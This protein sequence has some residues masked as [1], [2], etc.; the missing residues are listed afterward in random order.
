MLYLGSFVSLLAPNYYLGVV[1]EALSYHANCFMFYTGSPQTLKRLPTS[2][3]KIAEG[4]KLL[5]EKKINENKIVIHAPFVINIANSF[6]R[7]LQLLTI[8]FLRTELKRAQDFNVNFLVLHPGCHVGAGEKIGIKTA[9]ETLNAVL[10][11]DKTNVKIALETMA[12]K[13]SELG[14]NFSQLKK[15]ITGVKHSERLGVCF[16]TCHLHDAGYNVHRIDDLLNEFEQIIGLHKL[17]VIHINDAKFP[18]G[19]HYD[20]H[21]NIGYGKIGLITLRHWVQHPKLRLLPKILETPTLINGQKPYAKEIQLLLQ[22]IKI[23]K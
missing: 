5:K 3:L 7:D 13:G 20:R 22:K 1:Q 14:R 2:F 11:Y 15:I 6:K 12:G 23:N 4:R 10:A 17:F 9:I 8:S 16:D 21:A 18:C 19:S